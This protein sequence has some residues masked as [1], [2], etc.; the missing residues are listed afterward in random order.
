MPKVIDSRTTWKL[1]AMYVKCSEDRERKKRK[2]PFSTT[3]LSFDAPS[4][5]N[6]REYLHKPYAA[7]NYIPWAKFLSLTVYGQLCKF[8]N[9]FVR[10]PETPT[11]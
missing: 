9:S 8:S 11:H 1:L 7:R 4:P 10:K 6:T 3:P 2:S 5:V